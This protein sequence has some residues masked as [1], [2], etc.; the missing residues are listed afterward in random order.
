MNEDY[1][2]TSSS[3]APEPNDK[4]S[5][6]K[7]QIKLLKSKRLFNVEKV[8]QHPNFTRSTFEADYDVALLKLKNPLKFGNGFQPGCLSDAPFDNFEDPLYFAGN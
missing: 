2:L 5:I 4:K 6:Q 1:V 8:I 3:C 7:M